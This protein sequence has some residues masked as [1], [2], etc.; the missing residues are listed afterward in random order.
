[1]YSDV[2]M[3]M[4]HG[5]GYGEICESIEPSTLYRMAIVDCFISGRNDKFVEQLRRGSRA[6]WIMEGVF[7]MTPEFDAILEGK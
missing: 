7:R 5:L 2:E 4:F 3:K 1:M 6:F